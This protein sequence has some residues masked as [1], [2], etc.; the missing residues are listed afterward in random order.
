[1]FLSADD[2]RTQGGVSLGPRGELDVLKLR[3]DQLP[4]SSLSVTLLPA[5]HRR[6]LDSKPLPLLRRFVVHQPADPPVE[7]FPG[8]ACQAFDDN[9][10]PDHLRI[11]TN[12]KEVEGR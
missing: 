1:M 11:W 3:G 12:Q 4:R 5:G 2:N 9:L 6:Q 10:R 7:P 8:V